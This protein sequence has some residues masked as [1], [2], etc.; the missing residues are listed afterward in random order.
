LI[1]I[2]APGLGGGKLT[3]LVDQLGGVK[4]LLAARPAE[5]RR[6]GLREETISA[7]HSPDAGLLAS[8][9]EWLSEPE[10]HLLTCAE[11]ELPPLLKDIPSP[12]AA[13]FVVGDP[14]LLWQPQLAVIGSRNPTSGG[15]DNA[16]E[17]AAEIGRR[18]LTVTSGLAAGIDSAAHAAAL[19]AGAATVAVVG[20]GPDRVYPS[21]SRALAERIAAQAVLVSELPPGTPARRGHFPSRNRIISG[22]SLGV[23]VIEAGLRSGSL[24]TA[25]QAANQGR[26]VFALPGSIHNPLA[27]GCHRLIRDGAR[28]VETVD[29]LLQEIAPLAGKLADELKRELETGAAHE[30]ERQLDSER[31][32]P[33]LL[34]DPEYQRL[35]SCLGYDPQPVDSIIERT[36]LT[37]RAVSAMLL[38]LELRGMVEAH[39]G[40]AY[41]R[42]TRGR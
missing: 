29:E 27:K 10:H 13:L 9:L 37:A 1:A 39:R 30:T 23:L 33:H 12:P 16:R 41:S 6:L 35:W 32:D 24:I 38:M 3:A 36:G 22:L 2:R 21:G 8:D 20:T 25:R 42:K 26:E 15:I 31:A 4:A 5:L 28:L 17:F 14:G 40:A 11:G 7:L 19:D 18:G 34:N